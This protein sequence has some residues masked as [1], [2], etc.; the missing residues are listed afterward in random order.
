MTR[1]ST[2][3]FALATQAASATTL[4]ISGAD[5]DRADAIIYFQAGKEQAGKTFTAQPLGVPA[6]VDDTGR[7]CM[8]APQIGKGASVVCT[9][10][11]VNDATNTI[12]LQAQKETL[13]ITD[14]G[15]EVFTYQML[16]GD[17]PAGVPEVFKHGA[18]LHPVYSPS[19]KLVTGNHPE[20]HRWH[21]GI[22][23]SW[24]HTEIGGHTP[25]FWNLGKVGSE[26]LADIRFG[27]LDHSWS[28]PVHGGF[29]ST[30]HWLDLVG[31]EKNVL[32]ETWQVTV[33]HTGTKRFIFDLTST[34][35]V[36]GNEPLKLPKY[37]YGGL[38]VRGNLL[39]NPVDAVKM[40]T[41]N[42]DDRKKGDSTKAKWVWLGGEVD[43]G[44]TGMAVLIHPD[45]FRFPQPLRL[46]P[47][48]PQLCI[49]PSQDGDWE[50]KPGSDYISRYRFV[51]ADGQ[52]DAGELESLWQD[53]AS[54]LK[55]S[56]K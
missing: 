39:W 27:T 31:G 3:L 40:L 18:H 49:A 1:L 13:R 8:V 12:Q 37:H 48:N 24:T 55:A 56:L 50:I 45:N 21:R 33:Y 51:I 43:G 42:G 53:Y 28:G 35:K 20:D 52:P 41:S 22:W 4:T 32:D 47:K 15:R 5:S 34:Q 36:T 30:H 9:L 11:P 16:P 46:N 25:D 29:V 2:L 10:E 17:V 54:P 14:T 44:S 26:P 38:G 6:Q 19:G 7:G 23:F